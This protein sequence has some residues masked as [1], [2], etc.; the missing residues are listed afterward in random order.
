MNINIKNNR[1][2]KVAFFSTSEFGDHVFKYLLDNSG[3]DFDIKYVVSSYP[4]PRGRGMKVKDLEFANIAKE[5]N[6]EVIYCD[7]KKE[8]SEKLKKWHDK[9]GKID[10]GIVVD[11]AYIIEPEVFNLVDFYFINIHP[12]ILPLYRGPSP[13]QYSLLHND[14]FS[15]VTIQKM[16]KRVDTGDILIQK[17]IPLDEGEDF[18]SLYEKLR[19]VSIIALND[20]FM[21]IENIIPIKQPEEYVINSKKILKKDKN[22]SFNLKANIIS[23]KIN[24]FSRWPKVKVFFENEQLILLNSFF[25]I[26]ENA[27]VINS[28]SDHSKNGR[29]VDIKDIELKKFVFDL[30]LYKYENYLDENKNFNESNLNIITLDTFGNKYNKKYNRNNLIDEKIFKILLKTKNSFELSNFMGN[31]FNFK[32]KIVKKKSIVVKCDGGFLYVLKLQKSGKKKLEV[33]EFL[34]GFKKIS[35]GKSFS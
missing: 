22:I 17:I 2:F 35:I 13:I 25:K 8:L 19:I 6:V 27:D 24:A 33:D 18:N 32:W 21:N 1:K 11:F 4:K 28:K 10:F 30:D 29:I 23:G 20:F 3:K 9:N 12:S 31:K 14:L 7:N 5:N 16:E 26:S 15:G 34:R